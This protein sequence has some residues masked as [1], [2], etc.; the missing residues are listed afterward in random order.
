MH[1]YKAKRLHLVYPGLVLFAEFGNGW[2]LILTPE[3]LTLVRIIHGA[4]KVDCFVIV[5]LPLRNIFLQSLVS[6]RRMWAGHQRR[7][8]SGAHLWHSP[9]CSMR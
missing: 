5:S 3:S 7:A 1:D 8:E 4:V 6:Y 2:P 9:G